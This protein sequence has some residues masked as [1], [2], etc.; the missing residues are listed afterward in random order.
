MEVNKK[1]SF[2]GV[3]QGV[4]F[5]PFIYQLAHRYELKGY[6]QNDS[7]GVIAELEGSSNKIDSL[8]KDLHQELPPLARIDSINS[9]EGTLEGHTEFKK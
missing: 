4:G 9:I 8:I 7:E 5:R 3:V 1:V 2:S 6:V